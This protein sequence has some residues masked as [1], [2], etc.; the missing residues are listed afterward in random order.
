MSTEKHTTHR[1]K[2][3]YKAFYIL[4]VL[5]LAALFCVSF[6]V[7]YTL[8]VSPP[9]KPETMMRMVYL[10]MVGGFFILAAQALLIL[11]RVMSVMD[12]DAVTA[13]EMAE[14]LE[15]LAI[16]DDLTK[17]YNR[18]KFESVT[19][20]ELANVRRY[21][22]ELSGII[23]DVDN[24]K[25]INEDHGY[26]TGDRLLANLAHY[27]NGKLRNNDYLFRWRGGKFIILA[28]HTEL[29]KAALVAEKL[30]QIVSHKLFGGKIKMS[31]SLGVAQANAEDTTDTFMQRLQAALAGAKNSGKNRVAINKNDSS[32]S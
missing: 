8:I 23:F 11:K 1:P 17:A 24:F 18:G 10:I 19:T 31:I 25:T 12:C 14:R 26:S 32:Q 16:L 7:I 9:D 4:S 27:V 6:G 28:P 2:A 29:D 5:A 3:R 15:Q 22:H 13:E 21:Q 30:R 20:R